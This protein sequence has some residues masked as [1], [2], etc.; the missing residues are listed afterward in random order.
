MDKNLLA[1]LT[2]WH[3]ATQEAEKAK[4]A[5][6]KEM[7]L[8]KKVF[9]LAFPQPKEGTQ[10]F[11]LNDGFVLKGTYKLERK[12]DEAA[13]PAILPRLRELQAPVETL[14][15]Y[16][17]ELSLTVFKNLTAESKL[18]LSEVITERPTSP[19]LEIIPPKAKA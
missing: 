16:K 13:L 4:A 18:V 17:P 2:E 14:F 7:L 12:I 3:K 8:R 15:R 10:N 9:A 6:E 1:V 19:T 5:I 11:A